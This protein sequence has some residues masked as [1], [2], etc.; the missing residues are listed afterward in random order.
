MALRPVESTWYRN[1]M[2]N[3]QR[4]KTRYDEAISQSTSGK[5]LNNLSDNP[6]DMAYVLT[7]RSKIA[8]IEQFDD[9]INSGLS[10]L[11]TSESALNQVQTMLYTIVSLAEQGA[12]ETQDA[13]GRVLLADRVDEIREAIMDYANSEIDGRFVFAGSATD[14]QPFTLNA[15]GTRV[16]PVTGNTYPALVD[17]N[18]NGDLIN[19]QAET[20]VFIDTNIPGSDV[21]GTGAGGPPPVDIFEELAQ[22]SLHLRNDDTFAIGNVIGN[23]NEVIDQM[24]GSIG[25]IGNRTAHLLQIQ[26]TNK[27]FKTSLIS[28]MSSLEDA[29]MAEAISNLT[30]EETGLQATLQAGARIQ[31]FSLLNYIG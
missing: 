29:D 27:S 10:L 11:R 8:Q 12:S 28:K 25:N 21:F 3:L 1:F 26:G 18:G 23:F 15:A 6:S 4:T 22:L 14:T 9:N 24:S 16:D 31:R 19:I 17:Y 2:F 20:S 5:K 13:Q 7:L 30:R